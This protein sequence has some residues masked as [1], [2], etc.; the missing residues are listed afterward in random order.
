MKELLRKIND[1]NN[2]LLNACE[3]VGI[4]SFWKLVFI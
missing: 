4:I 2:R 3:S 1:L